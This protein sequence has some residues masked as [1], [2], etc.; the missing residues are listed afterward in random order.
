MTD[1]KDAR[2]GAKEYTAPSNQKDSR[3]FAS[4]DANQKIDPIL[5]IGIA[6]VVDVPDIE[7]QVPS[8]SELWRSMWILTSRGEERFVNEIHRHK[9]GL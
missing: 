3:P 5:N 2:Q 6:L 7:V 1:G 8:L 9:P 4:I